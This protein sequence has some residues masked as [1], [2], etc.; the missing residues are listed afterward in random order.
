MDKRIIDAKEILRTKQIHGLQALLGRVFESKKNDPQQEAAKFYMLEHLSK[1]IRNGNVILLDLFSQNILN[2]IHTR[3]SKLDAPI[4]KDNFR[5]LKFEP[6][7]EMLLKVFKKD[8]ESVQ[9]LIKNYYKH[10]DIYTK[11]SA[12]LPKLKE[13]IASL[14]NLITAEKTRIEKELKSLQEQLAA[15]KNIA[16]DYIDHEAQRIGCEAQRKS[17]A[18]AIGEINTSI[19]AREYY[20][21]KPICPD[22]IR[23]TFYEQR[24]WAGVIARYFSTFQIMPPD[25]GYPFVRTEIKLGGNVLPPGGFANMNGMVDFRPSDYGITGRYTSN[26]GY[27]GDLDIVY[28]CARKNHPSTLKELEDLIEEIKIL[29]DVIT[30][31]LEP[32]LKKTK[33]KIELFIDKIA[34]YKK[35]LELLETQERALENLSGTIQSSAKE[36]ARIYEKIQTIKQSSGYQFVCKFFDAM[37]VEKVTDQEIGRISANMKQLQSNLT[38]ICSPS[39]KESPDSKSCL[40]ALPASFWKALLPIPDIKID[41]SESQVASSKSTM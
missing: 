19:A 39:E 20:I 31:Q 16:G 1:E 13:D 36:T 7:L 27:S 5:F 8:I 34:Q 21:E 28:Y 29:H 38:S 23:R 18:A 37:S 10:I 33:S 9:E 12:R 6:Q 4:H 35:M 17:I 2:E 14:K 25:K 26:P 15:E 40:S 3:V 24:D 41:T 30:K 22:G 32:D 11:G